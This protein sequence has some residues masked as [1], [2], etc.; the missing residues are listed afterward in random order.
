MVEKVRELKSDGEPEYMKKAIE[1]CIEHHILEEYLRRKG[2]DVVGF[3]CAEY[4]YEMDMQVKGEEKYEEGYVAGEREGYAAGETKTIISLVKDNLL[5][6][7]L[8][9]ERL[10]LDVEQFEQLIKNI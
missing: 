6:K 4:D 3:L 5:T 1:Y 7:E 10:N 8:A 2:S 9:A